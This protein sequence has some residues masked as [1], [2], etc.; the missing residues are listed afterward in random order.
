M[1]IKKNDN[2]IVIAGKDKG[3]KGK[4]IKAFPKEDKVV[5]E[6]INIK[7]RHQKAKRSNKKGQIIDVAMPIHV[8]NVMI[9]DTKSGKR[10][11][12]A[13]KEIGGKK[14]RIAKKSGAQI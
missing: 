4:V 1:K 10:S 14:V 13:Y 6:G 2:I 11:R 3:S 7:K 5:V 9:F 8:S 12:I